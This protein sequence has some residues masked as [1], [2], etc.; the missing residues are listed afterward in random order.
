MALEVVPTVAVA[1]L[2]VTSVESLVISPVTALA[3]HQ[4]RVMVVVVLVVGDMVGGGHSQTKLAS[5]VVDMVG[6]LNPEVWS[7]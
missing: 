5:H 2:S 1:T 3:E 6:Y 4:V 7:I